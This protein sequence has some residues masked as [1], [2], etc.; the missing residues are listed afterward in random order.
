MDKKHS[1]PII[2]FLVFNLAG[3]QSPAPA[4][5][6]QAQKDP[7]VDRAQIVKTIS[8]HRHYLSQCYGKALTEKGSENLNGTLFVE[9]K[10][11]P[12][13]RASEPQVIQ[14]K[15]DLTSPT[16]I[17]CLFAGIQ[18]WDFPAHPDGE[19]IAVR[20]PFGFRANPPKQM[21]QKMDAFEK[22]RSSQDQTSV[23]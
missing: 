23:E 11:G 5:E 13:G 9:F 22:L 2:L 7:K 10:I 18:S 3:C 14:E 21:Q 8:S 20:Y 12:D 4:E 16:L 19:E 15:T 6:S 1:L 17:Q